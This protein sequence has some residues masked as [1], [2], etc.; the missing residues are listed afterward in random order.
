MRHSSGFH[1]IMRQDRDLPRDEQHIPEE[2]P[3][4]RSH[5]G[6]KFVSA[7]DPK[8]YEKMA[9]QY[10]KRNITP[11]MPRYGGTSGMYF[12][13]YG[14]EPLTG[15]M[16]FAGPFISKPE[17]EQHITD[18]SKSIE[19]LAIETSNHKDRNE[20]RKEIFSRLSMKQTVSKAAMGRRTIGKLPFR[21][22]KL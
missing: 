14:Q 13:V 1:D 9:E 5:R 17:A 12:Y 15:K 19:G 8:F 20:A 4:R 16:Y 7:S 10:S 22:R 2:E 18:V 6:P 11:K 21:G 3:R